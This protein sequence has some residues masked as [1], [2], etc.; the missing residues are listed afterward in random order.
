MN[1]TDIV[2]AL[3]TGLGAFM[4]G[5]KILSDSTKSLS[6]EGMKKLF[7][8]ATKNR[9]VGVGIGMTTTAIVQS[10]AVTTVMTVGLVNAG[11]INLFQATSVI[12]GAN[13][14]TTITAQIVALS[15]FDF[16]KYATLLAFIGIF[17][18]LLN[19][20]EKVKKIGFVLAGLGLVF[21][22][23]EYM[24]SAMSG[25]K[26][27][28]ELV[29]V[30]QNLT[31]PI[32][33][34]TFGIVFTALVQSSSVITAIIISMASAGLIIGGGGNSVLYII[35]G[36]NIGSCVTALIS[37]IG[38][39]VNAKRASFIHLLFNVFGS[40][41]FFIVLLCWRD[42]M[43]VTFEK[44]FAVPS[45]QIAMFH[46]FF[47]VFCTALFL[48]FINVFVKISQMV[49]R[50][51]P[52]QNIKI[53]EFID[54]R[55]LQSSAV[56]IAQTDKEIVKLA[57]KSI[58]NLDDA[59]DAF[60]SKKTSEK[61][62]IKQNNEF[63]NDL[64]KEIG[65]YMA[66]ISATHI[67]YKQELE[68]SSKYHVLIDIGRISEIADNITKY[69][70]KVVENNLMFSDVVKTDLRTMMDKIK[71]LFDLSMSVLI[72]KNKATMTRV[73]EVEDE[74]DGM[75]KSLIDGHMKRLN[76][77]ECQPASSSTF[78]NLVSN[79]ERV[80]DHLC[81]IADTVK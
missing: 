5:F 51:K 38:T 17:I 19:K 68:I 47:N 29:V 2:L 4:V 37:S 73:N 31:N 21:L 63:L 79:L 42:F 76:A 61:T 18:N 36:T 12:M 7:Y 72:T 69:T 60:L 80:G 78:I 14:G 64:S 11:V 16:T 75:R 43:S 65:D 34:L 46:T 67:S 56:A 1:Y 45:T 66:R 77:N 40:V 32:L 33:L 23:L 8:K 9:L 26:Q 13:I 59:L 39:N 6:G 35:L 58:E 57:T 25:L 74:V 55:L 41:L 30:L 54:D 52:T 10:S 70:D 62:K 15:S 50:D 27:S 49:I 24:S 53:A 71:E 44:W 48:P 3:L 81:F 20:N 28:Q 22:G